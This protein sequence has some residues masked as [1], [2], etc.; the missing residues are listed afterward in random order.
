MEIATRSPLAVYRFAAGLT[1]AELANR[2]GISRLAVVNL[3]AGKHRPHPLT[4]R[5]LSAAL[6]IPPEALFPPE[7]TEALVP[8]ARSGV[9]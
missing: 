8:P 3:E 5:A 1:Q 4:A 2:A 9:E 7:E 6:G